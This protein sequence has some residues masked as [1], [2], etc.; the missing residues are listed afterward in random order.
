MKNLWISSF[1]QTKSWENALEQ[2]KRIVF[3]SDS[4]VLT[5]RQIY[6]GPQCQHQRV[7][8]RVYHLLGAL[9][10]VRGLGTPRQAGPLL[11]NRFRPLPASP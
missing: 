7:H 2:W 4:F 11:R 3:G 9:K 5:R 10:P 6:N 8:C 1:G